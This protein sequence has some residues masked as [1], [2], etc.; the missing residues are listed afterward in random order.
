VPF[1]STQGQKRN[2]MSELAGRTVLVTG[3]SS[4]LG[5]ACA[6]RMLDKGINVIGWD[7]RPG[8]DP[9]I[10]WH[11]VD[12][13]AAE[14]IATAAAFLR[15]LAGVVTC[16]GL[17]NRDAANSIEP[18]TFAKLMAVNINGTFLVAQATFDHLVAGAGVLVTIGSVAGREAFNHRVAYCTS[19]AAVVM[20]TRCL[21]I[22]WAPH[23]VR[24]VCICPGFVDV[25]M[26]AHGIEGGGNDRMRIV[27]HTPMGR[28]TGAGEVASALMFVLSEASSGITGSELYVDGG[29]AALGGL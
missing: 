29:F 19:K 26:A 17:A 11:E 12:V 14:S 10:E 21:A 2:L 24:A 4:G 27:E 22:E 23:G 13:S 8:D 1:L 6:E 18:A 3:A 15:P 16:A 9:R 20:L 5:Q 7:L 28:L 25:G